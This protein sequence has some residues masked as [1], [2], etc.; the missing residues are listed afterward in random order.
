M[1]DRRGHKCEVRVSTSEKD[2]IQELAA[3]L[4]LSVS[5]MIRQILIQKHSL[6]TSDEV[7]TMLSEI[8]ENL[9]MISQTLSQV[10]PLIITQ[11]QTD[12]QQLKETIA[13]IQDDK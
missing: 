2:K 4:G 7:Y 6:I 5:A 11:L 9:S 8:R 12:V 1:L 3:Q 10:N 13:Q